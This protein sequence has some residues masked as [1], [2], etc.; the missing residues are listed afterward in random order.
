[1]NHEQMCK[2]FSQKTQYG[3][4]IQPIKRNII[5]P[6]FGDNFSKILPANFLLYFYQ[7]VIF[8]QF[9]ITH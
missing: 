4:T 8:T 1:M 6:D 2:N 5:Q 9:A 3:S 7:S